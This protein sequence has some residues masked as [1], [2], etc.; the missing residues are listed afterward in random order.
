MKRKMIR[1]IVV[2]FLG[3]VLVM[4]SG[5]TDTSYSE[6]ASEEGL[7]DPYNP[8]IDPANFVEEID[9][10]YLPLKP[11]TT[12]VYEGET[13]EGTERNVVFVSPQKKVVM[14]VTTTVVED[15]VW[16]NG[17]LVE[18]TYDWFVQ[19]KDGNVWYF[20]EDSNDY[21]D[22]EIVSTAGSW[23]A[24][25][26]GAEP[27]IIMKANPQVGDDYQQEYYEGEAEDMA[28]VLSL[29]E[30]VSVE[31][32]S[33]DNCLQTKEWTPLEPGIEE[34]KY[35]ASGVGLLLEVAVTEGDERLELVEIRTE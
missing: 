32:G 25:V 8:V 13:E 24:G 17:E 12:F 28:E 33:F 11:G 7:E 26:D 34:H 18:E 9:N 14:G 23:E 2:L 31:Y 20:G 35:Y 29:D 10:Q 21:E 15:R 5:C 1:N 4:V 6:D 3:V 27:G 16:E 30:S 19:D 22:G